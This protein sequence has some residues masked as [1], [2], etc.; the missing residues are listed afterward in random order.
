MYCNDG[1][2]NGVTAV[3]R[4]QGIHMCG[5]GRVGL[6]ANAVDFTSSC[7]LVNRKAGVDR[8]IKQHQ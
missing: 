2:H 1:V 4:Q 6:S 7:C 8:Y 3:D 5:V